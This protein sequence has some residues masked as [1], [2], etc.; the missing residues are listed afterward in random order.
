MLLPLWTVNNNDWN[1]YFALLLKAVA[2]TPAVSYS[3]GQ[4]RKR[5]KMAQKKQAKPQGK[6]PS[7]TT[8]INVPLDR[9]RQRNA[10]LPKGQKIGSSRPSVSAVIARVLEQHRDEIEAMAQGTAE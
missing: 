6:Q 9:V 2:I 7:V 10:T 1:C 5:G 8:T 3:F 4:R